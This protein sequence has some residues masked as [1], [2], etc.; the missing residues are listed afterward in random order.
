MQPRAK[1]HFLRSTRELEDFVSTWQELCRRDPAG[2]PFQSPEWLVPWWREFAGEELGAVAI[3]RGGETVGFLP[4]YVYCDTAKGQRQLLPL[5]VGT[6][7]YLDGVLAPECSTE[8]IRGGVELLQRE[9]NHDVFCA[10]QLPE[11]SRLL[12]T[13]RSGGGSIS[14]A[15][16]CSRMPA[17]S[18]AEL[19]QKIKRNT[20]YYRNRAQRCGR[21]ALVQADEATWEEIFEDLRRLHASRWRTRGEEGVLVDERVLRWHRDA[22][23][24]LLKAGM[25]RL[26][27]LQ[28]NGQTMA[29][30][31]SLIDE[32]RES[33]HTRT[34]YFYI[35]AYSPGH[36]ELRPGTL[37]IAYAVERAALEGVAIIDMLRGD[38]AYKQIWHMEKTPTWCV[39]QLAGMLQWQRRGEESAA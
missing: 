13:L 20:M 23:P 28:L 33:S 10:A 6:T 17:V 35:T 36:A 12:E 18:M 4:F 14:Q 34:Q 19:P 16:S 8:D 38:E 2:T 32:E 21:L 25:L 37:L 15:E 5:G 24:G 11:R 22:I 27:A 30:L 1:Y 7:D 26:M 29:V 3:Q 39:T 9:I 31:Y